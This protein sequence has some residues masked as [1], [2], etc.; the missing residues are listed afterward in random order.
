MFGAS[1][2]YRLFMGNRR[3]RLAEVERLLKVN[4]FQILHS[5]YFNIISFFPALILSFFEKFR[6]IL[7]TKI[8]IESGVREVAPPNKL[9]SAVGSS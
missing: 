6:K 7:G 5:T 8:N 4:G 3:Y 1:P 2:N 9:I